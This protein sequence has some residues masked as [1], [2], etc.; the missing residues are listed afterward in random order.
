MS[1]PML[2]PFSICAA[3]LVLAWLAY[4][5]AR[6]D[7]GLGAPVGP[8]RLLRLVDADPEVTTLDHARLQAALHDRPID[9]RAYRVLAQASA[10]NGDDATAARLLHIAVARAPRDHVAR[11]LLAER[12]FAGGGLAAGME[13][14]DAVLRVAPHAHRDILALLVPQLADG[15]F[16]AAFAERVAL[17]PPWRGALPAALRAEGSDPEAAEA[18]LADL[19][20]RTPLTQAEQHTRILLL[21]TLGQSPRAR[22]SWLA[23]LPPEARDAAG[24]VFDGGFEHPG[25]EGGYGWQF[26][27]PAGSGIALEQADAFEGDAS[28]SIRFDGR[29]VQFAGVR[30]RLA[31]APGNYRLSSASRLR[32]DTARPFAWRITCHAGARLAEL[33]LPERADW[34]SASANFSVPAGCPGQVL[35]LLHLGRSLA[36]RRLSGTLALD[37][38]RIAAVGTQ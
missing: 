1:K 7:A 33:R 6:V 13:H 5:L 27:A 21:D 3:T 35:Q 30:Q 37:A 24:F 32:V 18:L 25:I 2:K 14:I 11:A 17:D 4:Q 28:L 19:A 8:D 10:A 31:L 38:V 26:D 15:A 36:E 16:R 23:T 34:H 20:A 29:A 22:A 9:G 12:A